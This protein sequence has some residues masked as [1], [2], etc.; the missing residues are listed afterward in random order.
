MSF[1]RLSRKESPDT[2]GSSRRAITGPPGHRR[3]VAGVTG[4]SAR[5][6]ACGGETGQEN[7]AKEKGARHLF[8]LS[9]SFANAGLLG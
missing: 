4:D 6:T 2:C 8:F 9:I 3:T 7:F 1:L 5:W